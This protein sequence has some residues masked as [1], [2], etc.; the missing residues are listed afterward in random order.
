MIVISNP[1][2]FPILLIIWSIDAWLWM[3][4]LRIVLEKL[5]PNHQLTVSLGRLVDPLVKALGR[6]L[7]KCFKRELPEWLLW[8]ITFFALVALRYIL[9]SLIV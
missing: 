7:S 4:S 5:N 6:L 1:F 9:V 8:L 2:A 3:A